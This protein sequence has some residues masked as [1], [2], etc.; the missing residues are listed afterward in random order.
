MSEYR[1]AMEAFIEAARETLSC[2]QVITDY[3]LRYAL[4]TDASFYRLTP[5]CVVRVHHRTQV[6]QLITLA[7]RF[8]IAL[9][10]RAAGTSLS[11]QAI[12]DSVLVVLSEQWQDYEIGSNG[13]WITLSPALI[14]AKVNQLLAPF[15]RKIG[16]DPASINSC[17]VGGIAANNAS[18]MCCG[19]KHNSYH[20]LK[21]MHII[22][23]DGTELN[24][25]DARSCEQFR[26]SHGEFVQA[27]EHLGEQVRANQALR[28]RI[29]HK[30]RLKNTTGYGLNALVDYQDGI[31]IIKHLLIGSEGTLGF[32]ANITYHTVPHSAHKHTGLF[33]FAT[34]DSACD[35]IEQLSRYPVEAV[36]MLDK[37]A[38]MSVREQAIM[39]N[40]VV[41]FPAQATALLIEIAGADESE[42]QTTSAA[43][44]ALLERY[45]SDIIHQYALSSDSERAQALWNVRK[46]TFPAVGAVRE[47][48]TTVIIE[49]VA[50]ALSDLARGIKALHALFAKHDYQEAIIFGHALAGNLHFV[51]TQRF[52]NDEQVA[53]YEQFMAEV[54]QLVA[55]ELNGSL[56]AEHGTGRNM[57]PFVA[58]E[59]GDD[60]Y[61]VMKQ[62][63]QL[64][65]PKGIFNPGVI[66][67]SDPRAHLQHV[68]AL[69]A[70][71]NTIDSCIECG[72]CEPV[73]P[74]QGYT[75]TPRQRISLS[76]HQQELQAQLASSTSPSSRLRQRLGAVQSRFQ[77]LV[78]S[79]CA[80]TG[81]CA[82]RC[83]VGIDTGA[84]VKSL[85]QQG[86]AQS[87]LANRIAQYSA[88][89]FQGSTQLARVGLSSMKKLAHVVGETQLHNST[90]WLHQRFGTP[91]YFSAWPQGQ[92]QPNPA[93]S[94]SKSGER[95]VVYIP[96]C[97]NR[98]FANDGEHSVQQTLQQLCAKAGFTVIV[99]KQLGQLCCGM[100]FHSRGAVHQAQY[101][102][103]QLQQVMAE[104]SDNGRW[105]VVMD[106]SPCALHSASD[107]DIAPLDSIT[108]AQQ[109]LLPHLHIT[110]SAEPIWLH[111]TCSS[112][113]LDGG[114]A[115]LALAN[116]LSEKVSTTDISC[117]GFAGDKGFTHPELNSHALRHLTDSQPP[118]CKS[119]YSNS[120]TCEIGLKAHSG[121]V[122][123]SLLLRLNEQA[124]A[125]S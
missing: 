108:F 82:T 52:D 116:A 29:E 38:L 24:T 78:D 58:L 7:Q 40:E 8:G 21:D 9:T 91:L 10:F 100:A 62:I 70:T 65:D 33:T 66:I 63:K 88:Q 22:L 118:G 119:G 60:G 36:E 79:S 6:Q 28:T 44:S 37:R 49:D 86:F 77:H 15:G 64:F 26:R 53:R 48:G 111:V 51:F 47:I 87:R 25:A 107:G 95:N 12:S 41:D 94:H 106:A 124:Q 18:G 73:C 3:A 45:Q 121:V 90:Q 35:F 1:A 31:D 85:R 103:Q 4:G 110:P 123:T 92:E 71:D 114:K 13:D 113:H 27:L 19:V 97:A 117:C 125:R 59:W 80:A 67:N 32:I 104:L 112:Q 102:Q 46:G 68:K 14:G 120:R 23:A 75:L 5:E 101:K 83:P 61:G 11:G 34:I 122:F 105:P 89:H 98:V 74:S 30:Y 93:Q 76:R 42:L 96:S 56:K 99:P 57:A 2:E 50:F 39:P 84:Y 115:M 109:Y 81:L 16:P 72:F 43:V 17:K 69:P 55:V 20:T 54:A